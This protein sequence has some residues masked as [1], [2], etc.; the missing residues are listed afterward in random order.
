MNKKL[1]I[2][3]LIM[4]LIIA[5]GF[6]YWYYNSDPIVIPSHEELIKRIDGAYEETEVA[7]VQDAILVDKRHLFV[8][9]ISKNNDYGTSFFVWK[10]G[11]WEIESVNTSGQPILWKIN[12]DDPSSYQMVWNFHPDDKFQYAQFYLMRDRGYEVT[13]GIEFYYPKVQLMKKVKATQTSYGVGKLPKDWVSLIHFAN[14]VQ[15]PERMS[16]LFMELNPDQYLTFSWQPIYEK[17]NDDDI[18]SKRSIN[19]GGFS[20]GENYEYISLIDDLELESTE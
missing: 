15:K 3:L 6:V 12:L 7:K 14:N 8:P 9:Y 1:L 4:I 17:K 16:D 10:K 20:S 13:Q 11:K 18:F 2:L 5:G 19:D